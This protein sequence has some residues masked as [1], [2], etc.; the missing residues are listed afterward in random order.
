MKTF[1]LLNLFVFASLSFAN[2]G[3][4]LGTQVDQSKYFEI[5]DIEVTDVTDEIDVEE[6][7]IDYQNRM[8]E[9][10]YVERREQQITPGGGGNVINIINQLLVIGEK[11]W[12]IVEGGRPVAN[13]ANM[14]T[15]DVLPS[16][17]GKSLKAFDL[18]GWSLPRVKGFKVEIKNGFGMKVITFHYRLFYSYGGTLDGSGAYLSGVTVEPRIVSPAWGFSFDVETHVVNVANIGNKN[19]G[20]TAALTLQLRYRAKSVVSDVTRTETYTFVGDGRLLTY[21]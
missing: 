10:T 2:D 11:I 18:S 6:A 5:S 20:E 7:L 16:S 12:K 14:K 8:M 9:K 1:V 21:Q 4:T 17:E 13:V 3:S 15:V 19:T